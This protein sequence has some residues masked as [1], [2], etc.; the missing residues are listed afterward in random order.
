M[1]ISKLRIQ[2]YKIFKGKNYIRF[3]EDNKPA[4]F[5]GVNGAGKTS[6]LEGILGCLWEFYNKIQGKKV[7]KDDLFL[8]TNVNLFAEEIAEV[9]L[10]WQTKNNSPISSGF[11]I[12]K[13]IDPEYEF[14]GSS[15]VED[16]LNDIKGDVR[17]YKKESRVPIIAYYP[18]ERTV[19]NPSFKPQKKAR[20]NQF[21][22][23]IDAF[24]KS[25]NFNEFFEWFRSTED[26]ENEVRLNKDNT[27]TDKGLD[28]VRKAIRIFLE[29][30]TKIRVRR[31]N[32]TTLVL[33]KE[34]QEYEV[35]QLSHGEK[36]LIAMI[37]DLARRLV[38][39]NPGNIN[40]LNGEG[41][42]LIDELDLHLHPN[43]QRTI[44][45]KLNKTF[46]NI[47]F[48][49]TTHSPLIL[50]HVQKE[51][52]YLLEDGKCT[53]LVEKYKDFNSYGA[54]VEDIL[55]V[56]QGTNQLLPTDVENHFLKMYTLLSEGKYDEAKEVIEKLK[57][58]TDP[59]HVEILKAETK[60][61]YKK[62]IGK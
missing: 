6:I 33:E 54:E 16:C 31:T 26:Y 44:L 22:A 40:P 20:G 57:E 12:R 59:N 3:P 25:V 38:I 27:Y 13:S 39:A 47:Q 36:A 11:K 62:M 55:K 48:I 4:I 29:G 23:Y 56:V 7:V 14:L 5:V 10:V 2:D 46:P 18:V 42:V 17:F 45:G 8:R 1:N 35:N 34:G 9:E 32:L 19:L 30:Y 52:I 53:S 58:I 37:G 49:C 60:I 41:I 24:N 15:V 43:W 50:N 61:K 28:A 21:D 51:S